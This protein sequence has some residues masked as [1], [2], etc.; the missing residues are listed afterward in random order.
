[1]RKKPGAIVHLKTRNKAAIV[2]QCTWKIFH[3]DGRRSCYIKKQF[4]GKVSDTAARDG[5]SSFVL[6][7]C[8]LVSQKPFSFVYTKLCRQYD[9]LFIKPTSIFTWVPAEGF[10]VVILACFSFSP[11]VND[12]IFNHIYS[13][14]CSALAVLWSCLPHTF[15]QHT[16]IQNVVCWDYLFMHTLHW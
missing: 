1:M 14:G 8:T 13:S 16:R 11:V 3:S 4:S 7:H 10:P 6:E 9:S 12:I 15:S 5:Y 2:S